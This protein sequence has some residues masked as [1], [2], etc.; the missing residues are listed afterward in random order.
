[1]AEMHDLHPLS[2]NYPARQLTVP[3]FDVVLLRVTAKGMLLRGF[4]IDATSGPSVHTIQEW[5]CEVA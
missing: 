2:I 5:W 4:Q 1:M 3:L